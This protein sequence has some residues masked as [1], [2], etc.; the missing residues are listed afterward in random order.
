[1]LDQMKKHLQIFA[2]LGILLFL[3]SFIVHPYHVGSVEF[4]YSNQSKTFEVTGK[5][6]TD[7]LERALKEKYG[8][9]VS[10]NK[11]E[12]RLKIDEKLKMY[13]RD[14]IKLKTDQKSLSLNY[15]GYEQDGESVEI[16]LESPTLSKPKRV[17]ASISM[18]YNLFDD[19]INII[20]III[21]G[22]RQSQRLNYPDRYLQKQF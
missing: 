5:F 13:C 10:F 20:H 1:M 22:K 7:D 6:F 4:A 2:F 17:E 16:F 14:Y 15:L 8:N 9:A 12:D 19:Q 3:F 11:K 18:L 21:D